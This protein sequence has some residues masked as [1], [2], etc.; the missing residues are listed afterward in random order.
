MTLRV[1]KAWSAPARRVMIAA[2]VILGVSGLA[3]S[4]NIDWNESVSLFSDGL[5]VFGPPVPASSNDTM[6][7][8]KPDLALQNV[9]AAE[10]Q[11]DFVDGFDPMDFSALTPV[12]SAAVAVP[13]SVDTVTDEERLRVVYAQYLESLLAGQSALNA[14]DVAGARHVE[15]E[16]SVIASAEPV[17]VELS[18][19]FPG[20]EVEYLDLV[21]PIPHVREPLKPVQI[22]SVVNVPIESLIPTIKSVTNTGLVAPLPAPISARPVLAVQP[23]NVVIVQAARDVS[24]DHLVHVDVQGSWPRRLDQINIASQNNIFMQNWGQPRRPFV[25]SYRRLPN[26][27]MMVVA[28]N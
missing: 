5:D 17:E 28:N 18:E 8:Q 1:S 15:V 14:G 11:F 4:Q 7:V 19:I 20:I 22:S 16:Q 2:T 13:A 10:N 21:A 25:R 23:A 6:L 27:F 24:I 26:G 3:F 9:E 12:E